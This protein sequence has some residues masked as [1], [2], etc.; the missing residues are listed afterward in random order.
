MSWERILILCRNFTCPSL[1]VYK[2]YSNNNREIGTPFLTMD[3]VFFHLCRSSFCLC[4]YVQS[5]A[6]YGTLVQKLYRIYGIYVPYLMKSL[7]VLTVNLSSEKFS[8]VG[9]LSLGHHF[10]ISVITYNSFITSCQGPKSFNIL[11]HISF[12]L[13]SN[14][15]TSYF[16]VWSLC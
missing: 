6:L 4:L 3:S 12:V 8:S 7:N 1:V 5:L 16:D 2:L 10:C 9:Q 14:H 15:N 13:W 11:S